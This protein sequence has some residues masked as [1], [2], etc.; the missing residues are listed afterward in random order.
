[1]TEITHA[2][3]A[4]FKG[5]RRGMKVPAKVVA[6]KIGVNVTTIFAWERRHDPTLCNFDAALRTLGYCLTIV[7][8]KK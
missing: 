2:L 7:P 5:I 6:H 8:L 1:M 4:E 3:V